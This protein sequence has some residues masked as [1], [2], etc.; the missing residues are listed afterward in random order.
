MIT[1]LTI[2]ALLLAFAIVGFMPT[3]AH[4]EDDSKYITSTET[5]G[6]LRQ[7]N[8]Q[9]KEITKELKHHVDLRMDEKEAEGEIVSS[10]ERRL[11]LQAA[12]VKSTSENRAIL[13]DIV[14][15]DQEGRR[16]LQERIQDEKHRLEQLTIYATADKKISAEAEQAWKDKI[17]AL[18]KIHN[19]SKE[20]IKQ[21]KKVLD[22]EIKISKVLHKRVQNVEKIK[23]GVTSIANSLGLASSFQE[24][25]LGQTAAILKDVGGWKEY[26][27][28]FGQQ[29]SA[30]FGFM[31]V[32]SG[33]VT[34]VFQA[35]LAMAFGLDEAQS[36]FNRATGAAGAFDDAINRQYRT[37]QK[38]NIGAEHHAQTMSALLENSTQY[39]LMSDRQA[40]SLEDLATKFSLVG[41]EA[42]Q[43]A[44]MYEGMTRVLGHAPE[45]VDKMSMKIMGLSRDLRIPPK[46][47]TADFMKAMPRLAMFGESGVRQ[48]A[49]IE[50]QAKA[51]GLSV[52]ELTG[53][54]GDQ[55][56]TF[57]GS[58]KAAQGLNAILGGPYL[59][60]VKMLKMNSVERLKY[61]REAIRMS[62]VDLKAL[63]DKGDVYSRHKLQAI[64]LQTPMKTVDK[65]MSAF[66]LTAAKTGKTV[67]ERAKDQAMSQADLTKAMK[68]GVSVMDEVQ[69]T[70]KSIAAELLGPDKLL[71]LMK[72]GINF[73]VGLKD[74]FGAWGLVTGALVIPMVISLT[75]S[76]AKAAFALG[77][78]GFLGK[79]FAAMG[80]LGGIVVAIGLAVAAFAAFSRVGRTMGYLPGLLFAIAAAIAG[81][82]IATSGG[83]LAIPIGAGL[84]LI[85]L[86]GGIGAYMGS[87]GDM[88]KTAPSVPSVTPVTPAASSGASATAGLTAGA[89]KLT[90][91]KAPPA[92]AQFIEPAGAA[93]AV[94]RQANKIVIELDGTV[95]GEYVE[96]YIKKQRR[97]T[98]TGKNRW[99]FLIG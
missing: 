89:Q 19:M 97:T 99:D 22:N 28:G 96:D 9:L 49:E 68:D 15:N 66:G 45:E 10:L 39:T 52:E 57:E 62:G 78:A 77:K 5:E 98:I 90:A 8:K 29:L 85:G 7:K 83:A 61:M 31:N 71:D 37:Y 12:V 38:W 50:K 91:A 88:I 41:V 42:G 81:I 2:T 33:L 93:G 87:G 94:V 24:T 30:S 53:A 72:R 13:A 40:R 58:A 74:S 65:M 82:A 18:E 79:I 75:S 11:E 6:L 84:A 86:T 69:G 64:A 26:A 35:V 44:Q 92:P 73:V 59:N 55:L 95:I 43:T 23:T 80:P 4:A 3:F 14:A 70:L 32:L 17:D 36:S 51:T 54:F 60:S 16:L 34:S 48:F 76:I 1:A 27:K 20:E 67:E 47:L 25:M 46:Q 21:T 56:D 63:A